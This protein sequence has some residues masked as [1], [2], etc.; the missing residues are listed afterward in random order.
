[1]DKNTYRRIE[2]Y[3]LSVMEDSAHDKEHIYRVLENLLVNVRKYALESTR[4]YITVSQTREKGVI[5]IKNISAAPLNISAD[6]LKERFVRGEQSRTTEGNGL[7]LSIA[8]N[9][10]TLQNG[11]LGIEINGDL[12]S[13]TVEMEKF[14]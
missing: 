13:V 10:C 2:E 7:G 14:S 9:L 4:V 8:E 5:N 12:F 11:S 1:M 3:M 6:E